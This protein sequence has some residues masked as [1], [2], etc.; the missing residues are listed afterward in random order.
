MRSILPAALAAAPALAACGRSGQAINLLGA[1]DRLVEAS[2]AGASRR[3][4]LE[5]TKRGLRLNDVLRRGFPAGPP[6][7][8]RF[9][10]DV[11]KGARLQLACAID[12]RFHDRPGMEFTAKVKKGGREEVVWTQLLDPISRPA[13]RLWVTAD[14]D[15]AR[16]A[17]RGRELLLETH[18]YEQT[19]DAERAWWGAPAITADRK[20]PLAIIYLVDTL[21]ADHTGVYGYPRKM[22]PEL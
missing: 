9:T 6:G 16:Y 21:R 1:G 22:T 20:P 2:A 4:I 7:R 19:G 13:H 3:E 15:L 8:L 18:G 10:L 14:V 11:P 17:G 5:A 12:P